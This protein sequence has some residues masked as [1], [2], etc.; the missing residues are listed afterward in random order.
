M[1][2]RIP[3]T[4]QSIFCF[5]FLKKMR[6]LVVFI[7]LSP[8]V[9]AANDYPQN[10]VT[11][12]GNISEAD[13]GQP[14]IGASIL[15]QGTTNGVMTDFDGN[16]TINVPEDA[17]LTVSYI[18]YAKQTIKVSG[19][20]EVDIV[21]QSEASELDE[22]VVVGYGTQTK[23]SVVGSIAQVSGAD[24]M[25]SGG[26]STVGQALTGRLPGVTTVSSTGRPGD[27]SP[28][29]FIR[30]Q[31][32]WNG[33]GQ[34]LILVDGIER[35]MNDIDSGDI[36]SLSVLKD[37]SA[38]A[39]FG[40][41]GANGVIL[42]T[43][44]RG[45]EGKAQLS[46]TA[47]SAIKT[48]SRI[49]EKYD[50]YNSLHVANEA[51]ERTVP[52]R[53]EAWRNYTPVDIIEKY[54]NPANEL[55]R[56][57]YPDV[58]WVDV[59]QK[60]F[61]TDY[62][63]NF[64]VAGGTKSV[65]YFGALSYQHV[66][67]IFDAGSLN[68]GRDYTPNF[69]YD[70]FNYRSN[71]D[72]DITPTTRL[73]VNLSGYYGLQ[74]SN[75]ADPQL[76]Y[77]SIYSLAPNLYTPIYE[78]GTYGRA[79]TE[80]FELSNPAV[81]L[82]AKGFTKNHRVQVN[83]DFVLDQKLDFLLKGLSFT[84]RLS[85]DNNFR[86]GGGVVE[87]NPGGLDNVVYKIYDQDGSA[88]LVSPVG[89]NQ[90]DFVLNPWERDGLTIQ[91]WETSRRLFYQLSLNYNR[92]FAEKHN[93]TILMLMNRE[94]YAIGSMFPRYREDWVARATYNY[95]GRYFI[96]VN[97]AYN[98]SEKYGP[99]YKFELFP[100]VA[101]GWMLSNEP[102]M[103]SATWLDK[104]KIRGSYGVVGDDSA[105]ERWAYLSQWSS[106][107]SAFLNNVSPYGTRSPYTFRMEDIIGNPNLQWE[108]SEK[109]NIGF[110]LSVLKNSL[111]LEVDVFKEDRHDIIVPADSRS[112][113]SF[114]GFQPADFNIG[115][116]TVEGIE[117][118]LD[119][120]KQLTQNWDI[121]S[122]FAFTK[123]RDE[124][125]YKEDPLLKQSYQKE[126]GFAIG[127][128]RVNIRGDILQSWDDVY[129]ATPQE[130]SQETRRPGYYD[131]IDYN[132]DGVVNSD[133]A[134][135]FGY[136]VRP[137]NTYNLTL[138]TGYKN[139]SFMVQFYG[140]NN[141]TKYYQDR[142][143]ILETP[144]FFEEKSDYWSVDNPDGE[145]VLPAWLGTG[146][147]TDPYRNWY[148]ASFVRLKN[149]ELAY[150]FK[151]EN[152]SSYRVYVSGNDLAYWSDLPDDR[153]DNTGETAS[154]YRGD[155]PT[156]KRY[157]IGLNINF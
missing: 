152:G 16:Y 66:G 62:R 139:L 84:G 147:A 155:Y 13:T 110:E 61:A 121:W 82:T 117:V 138:G 145:E 102:F 41:K 5:H 107:G 72:F 94:E 135:P 37:A 78:D 127:Q 125:I 131:E 156:F 9:L 123:A 134:V 36:E 153:Q 39:V 109:A 77:S 85:Y 64:S 73:S 140:V 27:E 24:L 63:L 4:K 126:E 112:V 32:S 76:L 106:G 92:T 59:M 115:E 87:D 80:N 133:D 89:T 7:L 25:Q 91:D 20:T 113:P 52:V 21:M 49:P 33:G 146:G 96:D 10:I 28:Q 53:E 142:S 71:I 97:G 128:P 19:R 132:G 116:T 46:L 136:T 86:G 108:T 38:T 14:I 42:I 57:I 34:P 8:I 79:V 98:G 88:Q 54:R 114:F 120:K 11:V 143:F 6:L 95:D 47:S 100:S 2:K 101:L 99:G 103:E 119:Y 150:T 26:V 151:T 93:T 75:Q 144:L 122:N 105:G 104:F 44:K 12:T 90:F 18:G 83:S 40:V 65:K 50:S 3:C 157:N 29:I 15:E 35:S 30:G 81:I 137:Q 154:E 124:I 148:D 51:I 60:D 111:S 43:T 31:S 55:E 58:D 45:K 118:S 48:L 67:D 68:N 22:V 70:R 149:I 23:E 69:N 130:N 17:S 74:N 56:S 129:G 141:A 1:K